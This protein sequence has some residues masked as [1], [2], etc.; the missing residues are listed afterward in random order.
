MSNKRTD[1]DAIVIGAGFSGI[2]AL[3]ELGQLGLSVKCFE[4]A[5]DVGGAWYWNCYPG[6]RTDSEAWVYTLN[7]APGVKETWNY[8]ER[9]PSQKEVQQFLG[10]LVGKFVLPLTRPWF[11]LCVC[12]SLLAKLQRTDKFDLRRYIEFNKRIKSAYYDEE[13]KI[14]TLTAANGTSVTS[15]YF[16]PATG[17]LSVAKAPNFAGLEKYAGEWYQAS[18]WPQNDVDLCGKRV[19]IIGT[20]ATGVQIIPKV[21]FVADQVTVFQ[22]SPPYVLPG[23]NYVI[24]EGQA[25]EIKRTFDDTLKV[26]SAHKAGLAMKVSGRTVKGVADADKI[27]QILDAGWE[28]GGFHY[29]FETF[30]DLATDAEANEVASEYVRQRIRSIVQDP[31]T[32]ELLCPKYPFMSKRP[33]CGHFYYETYNRPNVKLVDIS[34]EEISLY[35]KGIRT[36]SGGEYD[37]DVIIFAIGYEAATGALSEIDVRGSQGI[38]LG[39]R[40]TKRIDTFA[41]VLVPNFPNLFL[42]CGPHIP[43]GNMPV[44][45]EIQVR[46]IGKT[47][48]YIEKNEL[49]EIDVKTETVD[50]WSVQLE[51]AFNATVYAESAKVARSWFVGANIPGKP[52]NVLFYFGGVPAWA[53]Q[54]EKELKSKWASMKFSPLNNSAE[55]AQISSQI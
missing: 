46:W 3:W 28:C 55:H 29:Q 19:A 14:W 7:F 33:P 47:I 53:D 21:A 24:D 26:A 23:R 4:D 9:Y 31:N 36:T 50:A 51:K 12:L 41:G 35:E 37:F 1:Y 34:R 10:R 54:L 48:D 20:G 30:D 5:S 39:E 17:P 6:A 16:L 11:S 8:S 42:I 2:R 13:E 40:W 45:V 44:V 38:S 25:A 22:R 32:A 15:R 49:A 27:N 52:Q 18:N 43:F